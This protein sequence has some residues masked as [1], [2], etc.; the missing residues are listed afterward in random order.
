MNE[1]KSNATILDVDATNIKLKKANADLSIMTNEE[2]A[3]LLGVDEIIKIKITR[4]DPS[5]GKAFLTGFNSTTDVTLYLKDN[6]LFKENINRCE[7]SN[8]DYGFKKV[9]EKLIKKMKL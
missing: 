3:T 8:F 7:G 5:L 2:I 6:V 4:D 9:F 1:K